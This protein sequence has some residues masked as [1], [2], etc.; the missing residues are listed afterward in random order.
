MPL[1]RFH[2]EPLTQAI[3]DEALPLL[4]AHWKEVAHYQDIELTPDRERYDALERNGALRTFTA[5]TDDAAVYG[6]EPFEI[7]VP[8]GTLVGY[9][10]FVVTPN[11][12][13]RQ[14]LQAQQ[15][16]IY[17]QPNHR[18]TMPIRFFKFCEEELF[19]EGIDVI[20][21]HTKAKDE[22]NFGHLVERQGYELMDQLY[23]KRRPVAA[24][25]AFPFIETSAKARS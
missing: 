21:H 7:I 9:A 1:V 10:L 15:D 4:F 2:R 8:R 19:G 24:A 17:I 13:Y 14:I 23:V 3:W 22:L 18:G 6:D 12:H 11:L 16:V 25:R 20:C 5:R